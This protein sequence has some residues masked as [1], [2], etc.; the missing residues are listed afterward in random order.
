MWLCHVASIRA[1][2]FP[3][4]AFRWP[5]R[6]LQP[7]SNSNFQVILGAALEN[8]TKQTG[9]DLIKHPHPLAAR[10][11]DCDSPDS[12]LVV[13]QEQAQVFD[14]FRNGDPKLTSSLRSMVRGL[15]TLSINEAFSG[16]WPGKSP[17]LR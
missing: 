12:I 16:N 1:S 14:E 17:E 5:V 11:R 6:C 3:V 15:L 13:L 8:Y 4:P 2:Q 10:L 7:A 9:N